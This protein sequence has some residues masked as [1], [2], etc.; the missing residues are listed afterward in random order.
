MQNTKDMPLDIFTHSDIS[1]NPQ[2]DFFPVDNPVNGEILAYVKKTSKDTLEQIIQKAQI[3]QKQWQNTLAEERSDK[4]YKMSHLMLENQEFLANLMTKEQGKPLA[5][6]RGEI[7]YAA[8]FLKWFAFEARRVDGDILQS[9]NLKQ[10]LLVLKQPIGVCAAITPWNFPSA[11]ITRKIAPALACGCAMIVKSASATPLSAYALEI[12][13]Q[14]AGIPDGLFRVV[15]GDSNEIS[16]VLCQDE[17]IKK[18]SFTG[19]TQVGIELYQKCASSIKKLSLELGGNAPLIVFDDAN[20]SKAIEGIM[21]SKFRNSGQT[22]VCANRIYVQRGIYEKL[23]EKLCE[24]ITSLKVGDGLQEGINQGPLINQKAVLKVQ[25]HIEDALNQGA[26]LLSG[27]KKHSLGGNFFEPTLLGNVTQNMLVA[28]EE[29]FGPLAPIFVFDEEEEVIQKANDTEFGLASYFFTEDY[30]RQWRVSEAL[31]YGMVGVNTG[32]IS[33]EVA[34]FG[35]VKLSGL[36]REGSK[37]GISE[38]LEL[39]Y[40]CLNL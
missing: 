9:K 17:R 38:Y 19:S 32:L 1:Q 13:A 16:N 6:S 7:V 5:E 21:L 18:L 28:K 3:A 36:G 12:L 39:K 10:K 37:Y 30:A 33:N 20:L 35:G 15:N 24:A 2:N 11:M 8:S 14:K 34:P 27:G 29:T 31:E 22:C 23:C 40:L 26:K 4:L 25:E